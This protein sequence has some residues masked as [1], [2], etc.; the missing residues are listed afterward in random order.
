MD[1]LLVDF[2]TE[3][4]ESMDTLDIEVIRLEQNPE[5][6][7][8]IGNIFRVMHTIKGTCGFLGLPRLEKVAHRAEN[9]LGRVRDN[10]IKANQ[11]IVSL[12]LESLD[13][14]KGIL[15]TLEQSGSEPEGDDN[16][17]IERLDAIYNSDSGTPEAA[18]AEAAAP[19]EETP[20]EEPVAEETPAPE[21]ANEEAPAQ[22]APEVK[23]ETP[24][25]PPPKASNEESDKK[26]PVKKEGPALAAQSIRVGVDVLE[27]LMNFVSELVLTRNQLTQLLRNEKESPFSAPLQRLSHI[28]T[29]LQEAAMKTRMQ[30]IGNAWNKL[31]RII[32]DL[33]NDLGKKID[34]K[35]IGEETELDRQVI[36]MI[37]DPLTH[38]VR[39]SADHGLETTEGRIEAGKPETGKVTLSAYHEGGFIIIEIADDGRGL[40]TEKIK[41]KAISNGLAT[42]E[43]MD[44]MTD[45]QI[46]MFI[47]K[48]GF[49]TAAEVTSVSG[50]GVGMDV[51]RTNIEKIGGSIELN[52]IEGKGSTFYIKIPLTL[53]IMPALIVE[54]SGE[55]FAIPQLS[56]IELVRVKDNIEYINGAPL[57]R[58]RDSL[59]ALTSLRD[60]LHI[61][62]ENE[63][64]NRYIV[65]S[66]VG[67]RNFG[68]M[69]D[70]VFDVE[71]IVVKPV[72]DVLQN[73]PLYSG[74]TILGDGS[75]IMILD[76]NNIASLVDQNAAA[77]DTLDDE[78]EEDSG[79][80]ESTDF[81][82]FSTGEGSPR[83]VSLS[84]VSRLEKV[85]SKDIE[86][87]NNRHVVQ[88]RDHL[89]P[90]IWANG[91]ETIPEE[92]IEMPVLVFSEGE[93][94]M[95][96]IVD[97]IV[98]IIEQELN[99]ELISDQDGIMGSAIING[100]ATDI[101]DV[102]HYIEQAFGDW[103]SSQRSAIS[104][105]SSET[106]A[107]RILLVDDS[108]FFR[109]LLSPVL[110]VAG[111]QVRTVKSAEDAL[112]ICEQG[113]MF[114]AIV[115]DIEMPGINGFE[116]A[117]TIKAGSIWQDLPLIAL[118]AHTTPED[119][120]KGHEAGFSDYVSKTNRDALIE[121]LHEIFTSAFAGDDGMMEDLEEGEV[122]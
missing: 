65:V 52:S 32:R 119:L 88:Y 87:S 6:A 51:V 33:G 16:D 64:K 20:A 18:P 75:V 59:L 66:Q 44:K 36:E 71:E 122:A 17:I 121:S 85:Q 11:E 78:N 95:G 49:S 7:E 21:A 89:M 115:S 41:E 113:V 63:R 105:S 73:I 99:I 45:K 19:A 110:S 54:S 14:I 38:M 83:A 34:L 112:K 48:P 74:N 90:L 37:R 108:S 96:L 80:G 102:S 117:E 23:E 107:Y 4:S 98:D 106:H 101:I 81:L 26:M 77:S 92:N 1:E 91:Q 82:L 39:N 31:P 55:R 57:L 114:D 103:F 61:D 8:I 29:E 111:Y 9:V 93:K 43:E 109:N 27:D 30:P 68:I 25:P 35:M 3:T 46:H 67:S 104:K 42:E 15:V 5:D 118:S 79:F 94:M 76:P 116:F 47:F 13:R 70:K 100:K 60:L 12:I 56:V 62:D 72:S 69:V 24:P 58:L 50:R 10:E 40:N 28:T 120:E 2:L 84:L 97:H 53:A 86:R 22:P